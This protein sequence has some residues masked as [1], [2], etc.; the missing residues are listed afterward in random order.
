MDRS[1]A[2]GQQD[3]SR[4]EKLNAITEPEKFWDKFNDYI[5]N[6][7]TD[8]GLTRWKRL[9]NAR[10]HE[11]TNHKNKPFEIIIYKR[12]ISSKCTSRNYTSAVLVRKI[13][14]NKYDAI[15]YLRKIDKYEGNTC[16]IWQHEQNIYSGP[17][18]LC[19]CINI[20]QNIEE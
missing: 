10:Y 20:F 15:Y 14:S 3:F 17:F 7:K 16:S 12:F 9:G 18:V 6:V 19:K 1:I 8:A 13:F 5:S 2:L 4:I 11:L